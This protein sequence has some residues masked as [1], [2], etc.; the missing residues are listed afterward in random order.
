MYRGENAEQKRGEGNEV[1]A[2]RKLVV[3]TKSAI[4]NYV[5][6]A[7]F[8]SGSE[9]ILASTCI[10]VSLYRP[11]LWPFEFNFK[12]TVLFRF[13][14]ESM[15]PLPRLYQFEL[16]AFG[17]TPRLCM[18][19]VKQRQ[20][21]STLCCLVRV[22]LKLSSCNSYSS[23]SSSCSS[24]NSHFPVD[25]GPIEALNHVV[26]IFLLIL[27]SGELFILLSFRLVSTSTSQLFLIY[28]PRDACRIEVNS[29]HS[30]FTTIFLLFLT[31][32]K[33]TLRR[34]TSPGPRR[35]ARPSRTCYATNRAHVG[36]NAAR[37]DENGGSGAGRRVGLAR[38]GEWG[39]R[40]G[41]APVLRESAGVRRLRES[42]D[43][44]VGVVVGSV[45]EAGWWGSALG[46]SRSRDCELS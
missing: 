10:Q 31:P 34:D 30:Y 9:T 33:F 26:F 46:E 16:I 1:G 15:Q 38:D 2:R 43:T 6:P 24:P 37:R 8:K 35:L 5:P 18:L 4:P 42:G 17:S 7:Y 22:Q 25:P 41:F 39:Q 40:D 28:H 45:R 3:R 21:K 36:E 11:K 20:F 29:A 13:N 14:A 19:V 27:E 12:T 23:H 44:G 32:L